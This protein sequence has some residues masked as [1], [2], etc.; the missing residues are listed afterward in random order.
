[1][2]KQHVEVKSGKMSDAMV[3]LTGELRNQVSTVLFEHAVKSQDEVAKSGASTPE[4]Q[5]TAVTQVLTSLIYAT[6]KSMHDG[7][8][9]KADQVMLIEKIIENLAGQMHNQLVHFL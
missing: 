2:K 8:M 1:L 4:L 9:D 3:K 6:V 7:E 5:L